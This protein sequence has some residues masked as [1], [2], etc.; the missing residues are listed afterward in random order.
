[1]NEKGN[2]KL[3]HLVDRMMKETALEAPS[4]DFTA[5]IMSQVK[6]I[7]NSKVTTYRSLISKPIWV[8][9][10]ALLV[11]TLVYSSLNTTTELNWLT[12]VDF[13]ILDNFGISNGL[14]NLFLSKAMLYSAVLFATMFAVQIALLKVYFNKRFSV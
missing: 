5:N 1:M 11:G 13:N 9:L 10:F 4:T 7:A 3:E 14:S 2:K 12:N 8:G 6:V